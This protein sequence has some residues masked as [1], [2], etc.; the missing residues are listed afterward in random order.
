MS[1]TTIAQNHV[2]A[3][4]IAVDAFLCDRLHSLQYYHNHNA[5]SNYS[6]ITLKTSH[7]LIYSDCRHRIID[8]FISNVVTELQDLLPG[9]INGGDNAMSACLRV[10]REIT[11]ALLDYV[12]ISPRNNCSKSSPVVENPWA[13]SVHQLFV[14]RSEYEF[15]R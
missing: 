2:N 8:Q 13:Q 4:Y 14:L 5:W 11:Q 3:I 12:S 6:L 7:A 9:V 10:C 1:F 15:L